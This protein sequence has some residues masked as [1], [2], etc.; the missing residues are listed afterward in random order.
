MQES[1]CFGALWTA[2]PLLGIILTEEDLVLLVLHPPVISF[3]IDD[4]YVT[5]Q[6]CQVQDHLILDK[7]S[8]SIE[9]TNVINLST[10]AS[11]SYQQLYQG[12]I[13]L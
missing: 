12:L 6:C 7:W 10:N 13:V 2:D 11:S 3:V 8:L 4:K 9:H 1:V 5:I